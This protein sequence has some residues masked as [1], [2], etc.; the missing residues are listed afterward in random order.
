M[1]TTTAAVQF[2]KIC[3]FVQCAKHINTQLRQSSKTFIPPQTYKIE[4]QKTA[5]KRKKKWE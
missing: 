3:K 4:S 5:Y 1:K 2:W